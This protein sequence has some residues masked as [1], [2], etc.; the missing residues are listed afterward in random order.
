[1]NNPNQKEILTSEKLKDYKRTFD[2]AKVKRICNAPYTALYFTPEGYIKACCAQSNHYAFGKYPDISILKALKSKNRKTLQKKIRKND[3]S[4]GCNSCFSDISSGNYEAA[5]LTQYINKKRNKWPEVLDFELSHYCNL[6]C[7]MC[8][9]HTHNYH[10]NVYDEAFIN[11]LQAYLKHASASRFFGGEPFLIPI[12]REIW[13]I[14]KQVNPEMQVHI[15]SNGTIC[16]KSV[17]NLLKELNVFLGI[18]IDAM[19][20]PLFERIRKKASFDKVMDN[21]HKFEKIMKSQAKAINYSFCPMRINWQEIPQ[22]IDFVN[23]NHGIVFFNTVNTPHYLTLKRL[24]TR[25][26]K[27]IISFLSGEDIQSYGNPNAQRNFQKLNHFIKFLNS[28]METH[29]EAEKK[30]DYIPFNQ[31][32]EVFPHIL[33][34]HIY[35][36]I[37]NNLNNNQL[38]KNISPVIQHEFN[39]TSPELISKELNTMVESKDLSR[40]IDFFELNSH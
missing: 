11:S 33:T 13:D 3:F 21:I 40:L 25:K 26:L 39:M 36:F 32:N 29:A 35:S 2:I 23:K 30:Y 15:Q 6:D 22:F 27:H 4:F 9:L 38:Q 1:M 16:D 8:D 34:P 14:I 28:I 5:M 37:Q 7:I 17:E 31:I 12:Y 10:N 19:H 20:K 24:S 18:S